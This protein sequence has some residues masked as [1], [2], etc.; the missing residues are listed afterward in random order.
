MTTAQCSVRG[1][2]TRREINDTPRRAHSPVSPASFSTASR[3]ERS[4]V[5]GCPP[6]K[7]RSS[8]ACILSC[9]EPAIA[10]AFFRSVI[11]WRRD[12][13]T[14]L[15]KGEDTAAETW[16]EGKPSSGFSTDTGMSFI[17]FKKKRFSGTHYVH[18]QTILYNIKY[19]SFGIVNCKNCYYLIIRIFQITLFLNSIIDIINIVTN[20]IRKC[21]IIIMN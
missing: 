21:I 4:V 10:L 1:S 11:I 3:E 16:G 2:F 18:K 13:R 19:I 7:G 9:R 20:I 15:Q 5:I 8:P 17:L 14:R 12:K 6:C